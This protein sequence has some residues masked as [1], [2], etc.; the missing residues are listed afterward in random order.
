M[1]NTFDKTAVETIDLQESRLRRIE[2]A[3]GSGHADVEPEISAAK[4]LE[5]LE[6]A[7]HQLASKSSV[8][9]DLLRL[10]K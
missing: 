5:N 7:L 4:R 1:D 3:V 6:H 2:Y 10:R 8:V 9:Q